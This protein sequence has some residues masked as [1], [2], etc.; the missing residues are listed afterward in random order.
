MAAERQRH[1]GRNKAVDLVAGA[2]TGAVTASTGCAEATNG[3]AVRSL[4]IAGR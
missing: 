3:K 1:A 4:K 2:L